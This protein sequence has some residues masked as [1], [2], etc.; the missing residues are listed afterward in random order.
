MNTG[1]IEE[2]LPNVDSA[3]SGR[4]IK[5]DLPLNKRSFL[6]IQLPDAQADADG[7]MRF[8]A[9][10]VGVDAFVTGGDKFVPMR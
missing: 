10:T 7:A 1:D 5:F 4:R 8:L 2:M 6:N 9:T 3:L